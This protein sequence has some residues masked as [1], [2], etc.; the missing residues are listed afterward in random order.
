MHKWRDD[1]RKERENPEPVDLKP[2][3]EY[4]AYIIN[5]LAGGDAFK[6]NGNVPN[7]RHIDNLPIGA[8]VEVPIFVDKTGFHPFS[9]GALPASVNMLTHISCQIEEL[10]V[11]GCIEGD[12]TAIYQACYHDP[13]TAACLSLQEIRTMVTE[14]FHAS[15]DALPQFNL[16]D[17]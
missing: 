4:A 16:S 10:A 2:S 14:M 15:K 17:I 8:C 5:A 13:L 1:A 6:F 9:V 11:Q 7:N 3:N 12:T